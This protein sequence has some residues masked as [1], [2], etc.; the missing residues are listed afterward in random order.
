MIPLE[1]R[2]HQG[3]EDSDSDCDASTAAALSDINNALDNPE[4]SQL[5]SPPRPR[6]AI[7]KLAQ[8]VSADQAKKKRARGNYGFFEHVNDL[9]LSTPREANETNVQFQKRVFVVAK[10]TWKDWPLIASGK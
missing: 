4:L 6:D 2:A 3:Q 1:N 9:R 5:E 10:D 8:K 7:A